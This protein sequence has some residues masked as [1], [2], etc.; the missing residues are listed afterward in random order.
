MGYTRLDVDERR[1]RLLDL[2]RRLFTEHAY[3]EL[4]MSRVAREAGISKGLLYHYFPSKRDYFLATVAEGAEELR[5]RTEPDPS[6]PPREQLRLALDGWLALIE[7]NAAAYAKL[8]QS[9]ASVPELREIV[10]AIRDATAE[11]IIAGL[12]PADPAPEA[13]AAVRAWLWYMD[14]ACLDWIEHRDYSREELRDLLVG[15]L[16]GALRVA[17]Y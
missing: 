3:D 10:A 14:G 12:L 1:R 13:R 9:G 6:L 15:T 17:G 2:G 5:R 11:R 4:S 8:Q 7:E 16:D